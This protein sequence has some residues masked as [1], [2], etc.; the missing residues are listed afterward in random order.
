MS[1]LGDIKSSFGKQFSVA[2]ANTYTNNIMASE[3]LPKNTLILSS[4]YDIDNGE[5]LNT[6]AIIVTDN[7]GE[8]ILL[9]KSIAVRNG[10][11]YSNDSLSMS[12]DN[13][14][15]VTK[16]GKLYV[17]LSLF[18]NDKHG[19][20]ITNNK[21]HVD[22]TKL[23]KATDKKFGVVKVDNITIKSDNGILY[24]NTSGLDHA[25]Q[26]IK[27][28]VIGDNTTIVI[29]NSTPNIVIENLAKAGTSYGVAKTDGVSLISQ[30]G[31]VSI[32]ETYF[33]SDAEPG[34][35][36][37]DG[38][39]I[40]S[41]NG[42]LSVNVDNITKASETRFGVVKFDS[43]QFEISE[44]GKLTMKEYDNLTSTLSYITS[45]VQ[46]ATQQVE[47]IEAEI[48]SL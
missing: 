47:E 30:N 41:N 48:A 10:L 14:T 26:Q 34:I 36:K 2:I 37:A 21:M 1:K 11:F 13:K 19:L 6:P 16:N 40:V 24:S 23:Q 38:N 5:D 33:V 25:T 45:R 42:I 32:N 31:V 15:I 46:T 20:E 4:P 43:N 35:L 17:D 29:S 18:V 27:G 7:E 12:L 44:D 9:S 22:T 8:A 39:G 28:T 3:S